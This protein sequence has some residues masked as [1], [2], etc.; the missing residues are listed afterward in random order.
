MK[1]NRSKLKIKA[2]DAMLGKT[3]EYAIR[4]LVY[5]Y[6]QNQ[7]GKRPGSKEIAK[8]I[9][10]PE[11]FTAKV[12]QNLAREEFIS[13]MKGR[14]GGFFYD[15]PETPL[16]LY[17]VIRVMEG[18]IFFSK[19]GFGLQRCNGE[20]PCPLHDDYFP[21]REG[22]LNLVKKVTI[23][24]LANKIYDRKGVLAR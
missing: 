3:T 12:L 13:S 8:K 11:Q 9:K 15:Q 23:Q 21:V 14:G 1:I 6:M 22:F 19:C 4:A 16:T 2:I 18:E 7:A 5:V 24:S 17:E 10:S 20:N